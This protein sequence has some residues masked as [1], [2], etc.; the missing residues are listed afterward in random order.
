MFSGKK[1][2]TYW[3]SLIPVLGIT[4]LF[5]GLTKTANADN[6]PADTTFFSAASTLATQ[7]TGFLSI[8]SVTPGM[9]AESGEVLSLETALSLGLENSRR[10]RIAAMEIDKAEAQR[11]AFKTNLYPQTNLYILGSYLLT[12]MKFHFKQGM[13][14]TYESIGE[15]PYKDVT[16]ETPQEFQAYM[17]AQ[18]TQP[19]T[20]IYR[21]R[22]G[23]EI[24]RLAREIAHED[25]Q[26]TRNETAENIRKLY[27]GILQAQD[28]LEAS[29]QNL[30]FY[31]ELQRLVEDY[32]KEE[33]VLPSDLLEVKTA[34]AKE[35]YQNLT[36]RHQLADYKEQL[37]HLLGRNIHTAFRVKAPPEPAPGDAELEAAI[38]TAMAHRPELKS[39]QMKIQQAQNDIKIKKNEFYPDVSLSVGNLALHDIEVLPRNVAAA[40]VLFQWDPFDWGKNNEEIRQREETWKQ[41]QLA[42]EE[43]ESLIKI[44]VESKYR[45]LRESKSLLEVAR[46]NLEASQEKM[47]I[48][49]NR[50]QQ[51]A[52]LLKDVLDAQAKLSD[53]RFK[54]QQA[55]LNSWSAYAEWTRALGLEDL[56]V[57]KES[58]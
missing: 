16:L 15:V 29:N 9:T 44:E 3:K 40:G 42:K 1:Y 17:V 32:L 14:G 49:R 30:E 33:T 7:S 35:Q 10:I 24:Y 20:Q 25:W 48:T 34:L 53:A 28:A 8:D 43:T 12:P 58:E 5:I 41:A 39:A 38:E 50:F 46:K 37:N 27:Y 52:A 54:Y 6:N 19:L 47:R 56:P 13:F 2:I 57:V 45:K 18:I 4:L 36:T 22:L 21:I 55:L 31:G 26:K 51:Q 23:I 11:L